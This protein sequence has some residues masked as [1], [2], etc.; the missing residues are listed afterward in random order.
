MG[1]AEQ[2]A[3]HHHPNHQLL[4]VGK[5]ACSPEMIM[6]KHFQTGIRGC[7]NHPKFILIK[8]RVTWQRSSLVNLP[9]AEAI[10]QGVFLQPGQDFILPTKCQTCYG[11]GGAIINCDASSIIPQSCTG[12]NH[13]RHIAHTFV[14]CLRR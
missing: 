10:L 12:E 11:I 8:I 14:V 3:I 4:W 13:I 6:K 7:P 9:I 2:T 1:G 5:P